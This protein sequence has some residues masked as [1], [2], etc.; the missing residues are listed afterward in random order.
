VTAAGK[1]A[2]QSRPANGDF[3]GIQAIAAALVANGKGILAADETVPTLTRRFEA[4]GIPSTEESRRTYRE[5]LFTA[6][7][8]AEFFGGVIMQDETIRQRGSC[9]LPL[10][11]VL[12]DQGIV[13]GV[14][15]DAGAKPLAGWPGEMVTEGLDGL[16]NRLA[17]YRGLGAQF[18]KWRAVFHIAND[19]PTQA[20]VSANTHALARYAALC[21]EQALVPI[22]EPEVL[23][24]GSH[25]IERCEE[26]TGIVLQ[27]VFNALAE[28]GVAL[29]AMLLKPNMV[30]A[31]DECRTPAT[32]DEVA[33]ATL[34]C[35]RRRV[36]AAVPGIVFLSGGQDERLA[37]AHLNA[38]NRLPGPKPWTISFSY[39]RALQD[40]AL[41][42]WGGREE[43]LAAGREALALRARC[44]GAASLGTYVDGMEEAS[45][46]AGGPSHRRGW[47][48]D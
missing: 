46:E 9:G 40:P 47:R 28:Q 14:K 36:P 29:E 30:I 7:G 31:G 25:G 5:M 35:L 21:Q 1:P 34:R 19:L 12:S 26:V 43:N 38:I 15:V 17:E 4:L 8:A 11:Q 32:V 42:A 18:A 41:E 48:D 39:G 24:D 37:T 27:S 23:M 3:E 44:N 22:V 10:A 16:R 20:C 6:P 33:T 45:L 13:P 2:I